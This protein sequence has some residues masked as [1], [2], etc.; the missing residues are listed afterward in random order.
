M[1][2]EGST[3][4]VYIATNVVKRKFRVQDMSTFVLGQASF[5]GLLK[6]AAQTLNSP[7][8]H[9]QYARRHTCM[10]ACTHACMH[11]RIHTRTRTHTH[12]L[13]HNS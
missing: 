13:I 11:A 10:Y 1:H 7:S 3:T 8:T 2:P 6:V 9:T 5:V 4:D 12:T